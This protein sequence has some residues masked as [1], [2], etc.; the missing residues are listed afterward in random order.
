MK[1][2][3]KFS[4]SEILDPN[5]QQKNDDQ[6]LSEAFMLLEREFPLSVIDNQPP[7]LQVAVEYFLGGIMACSPEFY[8]NSLKKIALAT[9]RVVDDEFKKEVNSILNSIPCDDL[10]LD[11]F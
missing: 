3:N 9:N 5:F 7:S 6:V 10:E 11:D 8:Q 2:L 1:D 4:D